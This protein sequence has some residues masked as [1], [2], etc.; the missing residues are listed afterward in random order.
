VINITSHTLSNSLKYIHAADHSNPLVCLQLYVRIGSAWEE[1]AEAGFSHFTE[2]LV[3]KALW[4]A[5]PISV[6]L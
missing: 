5:S 6:D 4:N 3:F 2:H 1:D